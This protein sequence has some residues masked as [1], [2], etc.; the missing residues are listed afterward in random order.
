[1]RCCQSEN[2]SESSEQIIINNYLAFSSFTDC[3]IG[4]YFY[5]I[6][7]IPPFFFLLQERVVMSVEEYHLYEPVHSWTK[8]Q[9]PSP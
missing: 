9:S 1:M 5:K 2:M 3:L 6:V 4:P 8:Q 7:L